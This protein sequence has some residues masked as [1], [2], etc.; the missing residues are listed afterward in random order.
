MRVLFAAAMVTLLSSCGDP[1]HPPDGNHNLLLITLDTVRAD[2]LESYGFPEASSPNLARFAEESV[3]FEQAFATSPRTGPSHAT[4][5]TA[6]HPAHHGVLFNGIDLPQELDAGAATLAEHLGRHGFFSGGIVSVSALGRRYGFHRGF[7][8][9]EH[10]RTRRKDQRPEAGGGADCVNET[11]IS[12]LKKHRGRR[13]FLWVHYY[14]AHAP[15]HCEPRTWEALGLE[16]QPPITMETMR[17]GDNSVEQ[18]RTAYRAEV[19]ELDHYVGRLLEV[20]EELDLDRGTLVA[21]VSDHGEFLGEHGMYGHQELYDE[22]LHVPMMIRQPLGSPGRRRDLVSTVDLAPT[23]IAMLGAPPLPGAQGRNLL[24]TSAEPTDRFVVAEWRHHAP[25]LGERPPRPKD[26]QVGVRSS[27]AK[28]IYDLLFPER[29]EVY[30][31]VDD[32]AEADNLVRR[33]ES[34]QGGHTPP[35]ALSAVPEPGLA[36]S[37]KRY[38]EGMPESALAVGD[39]SFDSDTVEM[40]EALGYLDSGG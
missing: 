5:L 34:P 37:L 39:V 35:W 29:S 38:L 22:V 1:P 10:E 8:T 31:L 30:D 23:L 7:D 16:P 4:L 6:L 40:L 12:W 3:V 27:S 2:I 26:V 11:A 25:F 32:A 17:A 33:Q 36:E 21:V 14:E 15:Y 24:D 13:F 9:F 20:L 19:F 18:I 28:L